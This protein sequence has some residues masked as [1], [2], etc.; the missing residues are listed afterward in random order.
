MENTTETL[1][2]ERIKKSAGRPARAPRESADYDRDHMDG[3][4]L[5][6]QERRA[7]LRRDWVQEVLPQ[8]PTIK[9]YHCCWL[10]TTNST[11][12]I[13]K[14]IQRGYKPVFSS[15][16]PGFGD[17]Y[18]MKGGEFDGC[19]TC[20]EMMLF[21]ITDEMYQDV[22]TINHHDI[23]YEQ[24]SAIYDRVQNS[25]VDSNGRPLGFVEGDYQDMGSRGNQAPTFK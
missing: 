24:E 13:Y 17:Q 15:E 5:T 25:E 1:S 6:S 9:G 14:R 11:D 21:K 22:M 8:P 20:S 18:T 2:D 4:A 12:P 7:M 3:T 19:I 16:A 10:S 23:P